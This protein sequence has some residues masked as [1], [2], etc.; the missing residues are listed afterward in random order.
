MSDRV[1]GKRWK[2]K[3]YVNAHVSKLRAD[4]GRLTAHEK[5]TLCDGLNLARDE[6]VKATRANPKALGKY[7]DATFADMDKEVS[8]YHPSEE[9]PCRYSPACS[10]R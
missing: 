6:Q 10:A 7:V 1:Q 8:G 5:K 9:D 2:L 3:D 4:Y